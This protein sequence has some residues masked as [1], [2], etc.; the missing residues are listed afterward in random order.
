[1]KNALKLKSLPRSKVELDECWMLLNL[2]RAKLLTLAAN[3]SH[4]G[5][6]LPEEVRMRRCGG[7]DLANSLQTTR[8]PQVWSR[9]A[10]MSHL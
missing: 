4:G 2:P 7:R 8:I 9:V 3:F 6:F 10:Q 5:K 1:M